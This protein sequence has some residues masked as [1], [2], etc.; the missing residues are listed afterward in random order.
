Y[1]LNCEQPIREK[2][3]NEGYTPLLQALGN[4]NEITELL[5]NHGANHN[6]GALEGPNE[7]LTPLMLAVGL[8]QNI[9]V[10]LLLE[11]GA[12]DFQVIPRGMKHAGKLL[13]DIARERKLNYIAKLLEDF[14]QHQLSQIQ[15]LDLSALS[16]QSWEIQPNNRLTLL[17]K[18]KSIKQFLKKMAKI[19]EMEFEWDG[20][21][22]TLSDWRRIDP[23]KLQKIFKEVQNRHLSNQLPIINPVSVSEKAPVESNISDSLTSQEQAHKNEQTANNKEI[24]EIRKLNA[25]T[26]KL[27]IQPRLK[28]AADRQ[29]EK[30]KDQ[31]KIRPVIV[32]REDKGKKKVPAEAAAPPKIPLLPLSKESSS[33]YKQVV[34]EGPGSSSKSKQAVVTRGIGFFDTPP[35]ADCREGGT[36]LSPKTKND[37]PNV[38]KKK[39]SNK[40]VISSLPNSQSYGVERIIAYSL[41]AINDCLKEKEPCAHEF[42]YYHA[43]HYHLLRLN[44]ALAIYTDANIAT[45]PFTANDKDGRTLANILIHLF[46]KVTNE[47]VMNLA[48]L[49][50]AHLPQDKDFLISISQN[51]VYKRL[52]KELFIKPSLDDA[53]FL[54]QKTVEKLPQLQ[55]TIGKFNDLTHF[56]MDPLG[57]KAATFVIMIVGECHKQLLDNNVAFDDWPTPILKVLKKCHDIRNKERHEFDAE[58]HPSDFD[59]RVEPVLPVEIFNVTTELIQHLDILNDLANELNAKDHCHSSYGYE[60]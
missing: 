49:F 8:E 40:N 12:Q 36:L 43:L 16:T 20:M 3:K 5:L 9:T 7:G 17:V 34:V 38:I 1:M 14:H 4:N 18:D 2:G 24:D 56:S 60:P 29:K 50:A 52:K 51:E 23:N 35:T 57:V 46:H 15:Q 30:Q 19:M 28:A 32:A 33:S 48:K 25:Q 53:I 11:R 27:Y 26:F 10:K 54:F 37:S 13:C 39:Q 41:T 58:Y 47:D 55:T 6:Q 31:S 42:I 22:L 44:E 21:I 45:K 59:Y